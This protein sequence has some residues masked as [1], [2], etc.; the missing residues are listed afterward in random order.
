M[1]VNELSVIGFRNL[2]ATQGNIPQVLAGTGITLDPVDGRGV[3][4]ITNDGV[5]S[6]TAGTGITV[7][8][9]KGAVSIGN[10]GV[11]SA[12]A[13]TGITV[14]ASKGAVSFGNDGV[15]S[16]TAGTGITV[17]ASKGAVS[18]GN[19]GVLTLTG[20]GGIGVSTPKGAITL[21]NTGV[22]SAS[23]GTGI[24]VSQATGGVTIGND[25]VTTAT[26]GTGITVSAAKGAVSFGNDGVLTLTGGTG[27]GVSTPKGAIS[28]TNTGVTSIVQGTGITITSTGT[29][30]TGA[31][32]VN[33]SGN[34][35]VTSFATKGGMSTDASTGAVTL[36]STYTLPPLNDASQYVKL[37][38]WNTSPYGEKL[39]LTIAASLGDDALV[40]QDQMTYLFLNTTNTTPGFAI[41]ACYDSTLGQGSGL[42]APATFAA[43]RTVISGSSITIDIYALLGIYE[44]SGSFYKIDIARAT[45]WADS[46]TPLGT[47]TA[48]T[49]TTV[50]IPVAK[51]S[52][53]SQ[54]P[55]TQAVDMNNKQLTM[56][57]GNISMSGGNITS[58]DTLTLN[59]LNPGGLGFL[60]A[61]GRLYMN[62][63]LIDG[64]ST[65]SAVTSLNAPVLA[66]AGG[67]ITLN[68]A[69]KSTNVNVNGILNVASA[70]LGST[71]DNISTR[72]TS[73]VST[74]QP[75][76]IKM[77]LYDI[78]QATGNDWLGVATRFEQI[79][80]GV[81]PKGFM[82]FGGD[83]R[84]G[85]ITFGTS[86]SPSALFINETGV[87][88][89]GS[90]A[91]G[92]NIYPY[93]LSGRNYMDITAPV[94][95]SGAAGA[96]RLVASSGTV[97]MTIT[98]TVTLSN[99]SDISTSFSGNYQPLSWNNGQGAGL[100][101]VAAGTNAYSDSAVAGDTVI[102]SNANKLIL[103]SG[104]GVPAGALVIDT[105]NNVTISN[106]L[107]GHNLYV[108][109]CFQMNETSTRT[110]TTQYPELPLLENVLT[111]VGITKYS[112]TRFALTKSGTYRFVL[113]LL[114]MNSSAITQTFVTQMSY[115]DVGTVAGSVR[116]FL[117]PPGSSSY[118][119]N[120]IL[121]GY[122]GGTLNYGAADL[123]SGVTLRI[124]RDIIS[125]TN[126]SDLSIELIG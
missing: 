61:G 119:S 23:A 5:G 68:P 40:S 62:N 30:G 95:I 9:S 12:A 106:K 39:V 97:V 91:A 92:A 89:F 84:A 17:S 7:S 111:N 31:V 3:V 26:A 10:D 13:G 79:I 16:A 82:Q 98:D 45:S 115:S 48:P 59:Y 24:T 6:V 47:T 43:K 80:D 83:G 46:S 50:A 122:T 28:L 103:Q 71:I 77:R 85:G 120:V 125:G 94:A 108:Y 57:G 65:I 49:G 87:S 36:A 74:A 99:V 32:T 67:T 110:I 21:T 33:A 15:V 18:F 104:N 112:S 86:V 117:A 27:I 105:S 90:K 126:P 2:F 44:G 78:R 22:T 64:A 25:G 75:N 20:G 58:C 19:D 14:S 29:G 52:V 66:N 55:A 118:V 93:T 81:A 96:L 11:V 116:K 109:G 54:F 1:D 70:N 51:A 123:G 113:T 69:S 53:W 41:A 73:E 38:T 114:V 72:F 88:Y 42:Q 100:I 37:G 107:N 34:A 101:G 35:G 60:Y 4:T 121:N 76:A 56:A 63:N 124:E 102:K 8:A